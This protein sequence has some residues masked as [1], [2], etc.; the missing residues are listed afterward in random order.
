MYLPSYE[1]YL[2]HAPLINNSAEVVLGGEAQFSFNIRY[3]PSLVA[4]SSTEDHN[5][6]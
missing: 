3:S 6:P 2:C 5:V 1:I 4:A